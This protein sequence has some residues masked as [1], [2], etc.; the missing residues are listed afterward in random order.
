[1]EPLRSFDMA[2][3]TLHCFDVG[4]EVFRPTI[5]KWVKGFGVKSGIIHTTLSIVINSELGDD[6]YVVP[7]RKE[8]WYRLENRIDGNIFPYFSNTDII[9]AVHSKHHRSMAHYEKWG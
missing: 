4:L 2:R 5:A 6:N 9:K 8:N 3:R 1:M 7:L